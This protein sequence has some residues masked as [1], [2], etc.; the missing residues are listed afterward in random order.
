S[1][2]GIHRFVDP[3]EALVY[4]NSQF[5]PADARR[6]YTNIEHPELEANLQMTML[7][8]DT[9][10]IASNGVESQREQLGAR[11]AKVQFAAT[12]PISTYLTTFLAGPYAQFKDVGSGHEATNPP[13]I[14]LR[15]FTRQS[16]VDYVDADV[17]FDQT[18][19]G[20]TW[21]HKQF[22]VPYPWGKYDQAF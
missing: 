6:A 16:L 8:P 1:G 12:K 19:R 4:F 9:W 15:I 20:L 5:A 2:E 21:F 18:K 11:T 14:E 7:G 10:T 3:V 13:P 17:L 22:Q